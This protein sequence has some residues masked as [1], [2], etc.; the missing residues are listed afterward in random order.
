MATKLELLEQLKGVRERQKEL[1]DRA[2]AENRDLSAEELNNFNSADTE[3]RAL[4]GRIARQTA[5]ERT[6]MGDE[7][8]G[9]TITAPQE[10]RGEHDEVRTMRM[11]ET[12][13]YK[14]AFRKWLTGTD[15]LEPAEYRTLAAGRQIV[16]AD[17][18]RA[19]GVNNPTGAGYL[20]PDEFVRSIMQN[21]LAFGGMREAATIMTTDTGA[22]L[23]FPTSDDTGNTGELL[24]E[25]ASATQQDVSVGG[26]TLKALK[27]SSKEVRV[28]MELLQ[29]SA[30]DIE[31]WLSGLL[32]ERIARITNTHFTTGAAPNQPA[33]VTLDA[34]T[35]V[36]GATGQTTSVTWDDLINLE[37]SVDPAYRKNARFMFNDAT[38]SYLRRIKDGNGQYLWQ[39]AV[40]ANAP[41]LVNGWPYTINQ[42]M[43]SMAA[44]AISIL[45]GDFSKYIIRDVRGFSLLRLNELY[46]VS[47]Q[48]GFLGFSRHDGA[49]IHA[50][51]NPIQ[52]YVNAA[53]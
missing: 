8:R 40:T 51:T 21:M 29:D 12:D 28:S 53:S 15:M 27:Y 48:V 14:K 39:P 33:G 4:E 37:H 24:G 36:S 6:P 23:F 34:G 41:A 30:F 22:D 13:S 31:S 32:G 46:A 2:E 7:E 16:T 42:S 44:S 47:G 49:L 3:L 11:T 18:M 20:V 38:L 35:G 1:V 25:H 52:A 50:G 45:F 10:N 26:R 9:R 17:E 43:A 5:L 19:I